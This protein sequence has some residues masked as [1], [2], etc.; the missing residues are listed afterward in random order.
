M[1]VVVILKLVVIRARVPGG[2]VAVAVTVN[3]VVVVFLN[4]FFLC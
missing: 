1:N 4:V 3:A 2:I